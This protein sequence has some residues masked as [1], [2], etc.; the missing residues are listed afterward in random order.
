[1]SLNS[2]KKPELVD[3]CV[4]RLGLSKSV[5]NKFKKAELVQKLSS[6]S[7]KSKKSPKKKTVRRRSKVKKTK[8]RKSLKKSPKRK[9]LKKSPKKS[10]VKRIAKKD[11]AYGYWKLG[12]LDGKIILPLKLVS[13]SDSYERLTTKVGYNGRPIKQIR[14][15]TVEGVERPERVEDIEEIAPWNG[16]GLYLEEDGQ[17]VPL[18]EYDGLEDL[19]EE[20]KEKRKERYMEVLGLYDYRDF[21]PKY[22]NDRQFYAIP[23]SGGKHGDASQVEMEM[24]QYLIEFLNQFDKVLLVK[25]FSAKGQE[26]GLMYPESDYLRLTGLSSAKSI[27]HPGEILKV[28]ENSGTQKLF[29]EKL[30]K[31]YKDQGSSDDA[32]VLDWKDHYNDSLEAHGLLKRGLRKVKKVKEVPGEDLMNMLQN[33]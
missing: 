3:L 33:L 19:L 12:L 31:F 28:S 18:S 6:G 17:L 8:A 29:S 14:V 5:C 23:G 30:R 20:D 27:K 21:N 11:R 10:P 9:S 24:Y 1:M 7:G 22:F 4:E 25:Y 2:K 16:D 13:G 32:L 15:T 26:L